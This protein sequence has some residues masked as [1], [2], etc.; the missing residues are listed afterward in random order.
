MSREDVY[1]RFGRENP[2]AA[3]KMAEVLGDTFAQERAVVDALALR[4]LVPRLDMALY[5]GFA[6]G[7]VEIFG[8]ESAG[9]TTLLCTA[10]ASAQRQGKET[11]LC[12]TEDKD[13]DYWV[14]LGVDTERLLLVDA[15][16]PDD[17]IDMMVD[18]IRTPNRVLAV[19]SVTALRPLNPEYEDDQSF[20]VWLDVVGD[21]LEEV[22]GAMP[23]TSV[24][25][26]TSQVRTRKSVNPKMKFAQGIETAS[27]RL[28]N[29]F[30]ARLELS[31][32]QVSE[33]DYTLVVNVIAN[34]LG[35]PAKYIRIPVT[36][37]LGI[38]HCLDAVRVAAEIGVIDKNGPWY[39]MPDGSVHHGEVAASGVVDVDELCEQI[40]TWRTRAW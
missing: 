27:R 32:E 37:G 2:V 9:K 31:R 17:M 19:D 23:P 13:I 16:D 14:K 30:S 34:T 24:M 21:I 4:S 5:G 10:I 3:D 6:S 11:A 7:I 20:M 29:Q 15:E 28:V 38:D 40:E 8:A 22:N 25:L 12:A 35:P 18:F 39:R 26:L 36:K 1:E 33:N